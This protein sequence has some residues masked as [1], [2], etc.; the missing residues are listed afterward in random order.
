MN[1]RWLRA[2][3]LLSIVIC[4]GVAASAQESPDDPK[5]Y[6]VIYNDG[7]QVCVDLIGYD[8]FYLSSKIIICKVVGESAERRIPWSDVKQISNRWK[9]LINAGKA[10]YGQNPIKEESPHDESSFRLRMVGPTKATLEYADGSIKTGMLTSV[11]GSEIGFAENAKSEVGVVGISLTGT[12][13]KTIKIGRSTYEYSGTAGA[14]FEKTGS[15][16]WFKIAWAVFDKYKLH[17]LWIVVVY[18]LVYCMWPAFMGFRP[19]PKCGYKKGRRVGSGRTGEEVERTSYD[20]VNVQ[21]YDNVRQ[22]AYFETKAR[23]KRWTDVTVAT[24][25][26]CRRCKHRWTALSV[27]ERGMSESIEG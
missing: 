20:R 27:E 8:A 24:T 2:I 1:S 5:R 16:H 26:R 21:Q 10:S 12:I 14:F 7:R 4:H 3:C 11:L 25:Y 6:V 13:P 17:I 18:F 15:F 22:E 23:T 19:C 9:S